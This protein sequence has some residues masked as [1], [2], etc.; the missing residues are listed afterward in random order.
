VKGAGRIEIPGSLLGGG[1]NFALTVCGD[2]MRGAGIRDGDVV[3]VRRQATAGD[4]QTVA[5]VVGGE[6]IVRRLRR[7][8]SRIELRPANPAF[9]TISFEEGD[10]GVEIRGV[11]VGLIRKFRR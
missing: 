6:T 9:E 4:G 8:G 1:E 7:Q 5:A 10:P 11:V 3:I 2:G